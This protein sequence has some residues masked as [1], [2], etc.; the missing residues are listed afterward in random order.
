M[1]LG[2]D[3]YLLDFPE[4]KEVEKIWDETRE[5]LLTVSLT[6]KR[7]QNL[8]AAWRNYKN[9]HKNWK[10]LVKDLSDF[11]KGKISIERDEIEPYNPNLLKLIAIDFIS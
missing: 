10:H 3:E 2:L 5:K 11:L 8:R 6:K 7:L 9:N 1:D 4:D